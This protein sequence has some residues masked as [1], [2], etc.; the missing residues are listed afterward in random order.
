MLQL[1]AVATNLQSLKEQLAAKEALERAQRVICGP[2]RTGADFYV[3]PTPTLCTWFLELLRRYAPNLI[4]TAFTGKTSIPTNPQ[5]DPEPLGAF[6][7]HSRPL[8]AHAPQASSPSNARNTKHHTSGGEPD[9]PLRSRINLTSALKYSNTNLW[10]T[11]VTL[12]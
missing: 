6:T 3:P 11:N 10:I 12:G 7:S 4:M 9:R 8:A 1:I 2:R 5:N